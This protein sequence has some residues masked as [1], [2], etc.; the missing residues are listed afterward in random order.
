M[1]KQERKE[2]MKAYREANRDKAKASSKAWRNANREKS[3]AYSKAWRE[4]NKEYDKA[5]REANREKYNASSRAWQEANTTHYV[6]YKHTNKAGDVYIG[7][8][9]NLRPYVKNSSS[10]SKAWI[11]AF[12]NGFEIEILKEFSNKEDA[13][14]YESELINKI[15]LESLVNVRSINQIK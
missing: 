10:R 3:K 12:S 9:H 4:E 15:G 8:G 6:T 5:Y 1:T 11:K 7:S 14:R 13:L 2:Y